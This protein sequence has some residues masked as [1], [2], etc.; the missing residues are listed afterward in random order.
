[1]ETD[2]RGCSLSRTDILD[3]VVTKS[4][5]EKVIFQLKI[6]ERQQCEDQEESGPARKKSKYEG[7]RTE[8]SL[9]KEEA[10]TAGE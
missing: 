2:C 4:L 10:R 9:L 8:M 6:G 1:M 3:D 7:P 5:S